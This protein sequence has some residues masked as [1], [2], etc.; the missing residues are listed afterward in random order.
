MHRASPSPSRTSQVPKCHLG[1]RRDSGSTQTALDL[2]CRGFRQTH[3]SRGR[4]LPHTQVHRDWGGKHSLNS[5]PD[6][7]LWHIPDYLRSDSSKDR[8]TIH[9]EQE[10]T[11]PWHMN[12]SANIS[13][14]DSLSGHCAYFPSTS[15]GFRGAVN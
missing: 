1:D 5:T 12:T 7:M 15:A 13:R 14:G 6:C 8:G 10:V 2:R 9:T 11:D 3:P 4:R